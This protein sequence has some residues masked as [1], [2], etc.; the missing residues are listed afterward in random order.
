MSTMSTWATAKTIATHNASETFTLR[1]TGYINLLYLSKVSNRNFFTNRVL[2]AISY[3]NLTKVTNR[4]Y[5]LLSKVTSHRLVYLLLFD[6]TKAK[7]YGFI[8]IGS[9][10]L[11][12]A[13]LVWSSFDNGYRNYLAVFVEELS[14][15]DFLT[16][17]SVNHV[18]S[19]SPTA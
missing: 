3:A 6:G 7:L 4:L 16:V 9:S 10:G 1:S 18:I 5:T 17:D 19:H 2:S 13:Y 12:L 15:A 8:A 11:Y 14:H